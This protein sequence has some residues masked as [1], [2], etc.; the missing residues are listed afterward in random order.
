MVSI[1]PGPPQFPASGRERE[2]FF[3]HLEWTPD[4]EWDYTTTRVL[5]GD[6]PDG[7]V[8]VAPEGWELNADRWPR[9]DEGWTRVGPG[10]LLNPYAPGGPVLIAH[11]RKR[12]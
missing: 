8:P 4:G 5:A 7:W 12:R 9:V 3:H 11:W 6:H 2:R 10:V 1:H